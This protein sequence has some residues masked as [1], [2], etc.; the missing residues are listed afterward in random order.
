L[1]LR[2]K[3][4]KSAAELTIIL[5]VAVIGSLTLSSYYAPS[6]SPFSQWFLAITPLAVA[7]ATFYLS[8]SIARD[9]RSREM[10]ALVYT[11]LLKEATTWLN[12]QFQM[13]SEWGRIKTEQPYWV[14]R[15][16]K[17]IIAI[18]KK[19][20]ELFQK[21]W[22]LRGTVTK[23]I[24]DATDELSLEVLAKGG[25]NTNDRL[26][27]IQF[28][29]MTEEGAGTNLVYPIW[30]WERGT[31]ISEFAEDLAKKNY[32]R[33][34]KWSLKTEASPRTGGSMKIAGGMEETKQWL[35][36]IMES[37]GKQPDA[38]AYRKN[39]EAV[40]KLGTQ[41]LLLIEEELA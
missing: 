16:P 2:K 41:A 19:A 18:F 10:A 22:E 38:I 37:V 4:R 26:A 34:T 9:R 40:T 39:I 32:P 35:G 27:N 33:G 15:V 23:I 17:E 6:L 30:L 20:E 3:F 5:I 11:P 14:L 25:F 1:K 24:S 29:V 21:Q 36:K 28:Y 31:S 8:V 13:F 7:F 12:P